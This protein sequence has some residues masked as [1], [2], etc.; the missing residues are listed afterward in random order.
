MANNA[1]LGGRYRYL[2]RLPLFLETVRGDLSTQRIGNTELNQLDLSG[3]IEFTARVRLT[4]RSVYSFVDNE[5]IRN[6]GILEYVSKCKCWGIG[7]SVNHERRQGFSGGF[8]IRF[9]GLGEEKSNLFEGG[10]G[11]GINL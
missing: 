10:F 11:A 7:A 3:R 4:Y 8:E 6:Q 2:R 1:N 5:F 9:L